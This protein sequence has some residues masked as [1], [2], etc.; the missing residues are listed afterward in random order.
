MSKLVA[1]VNWCLEWFRRPLPLRALVAFVLALIAILGAL[2]SEHIPGMEPCELCLWQRWPY[3]IGLP[4]L[5]LVLVFWKQIPVILRIGLTLVVAVTFVVSIGLASYHAGVEY[6]IWPGP[7]SCTNLDEQ[8]S[9]ADLD[10]PQAVERVIPC[11]V[12]PFTIFGISMAGFNALASAVIAGL[13]FWSA[14]GQWQRSRTKSG[15]GRSN[16]A[17]G[18]SSVSQ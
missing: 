3:Y 7:S 5:A 4:I 11:D 13:L 9:F 16:G 15:G 18:S 14:L 12:A 10:N 1:F 2:G 17:Y 6:R 8:L